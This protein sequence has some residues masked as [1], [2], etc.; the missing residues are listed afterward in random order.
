MQQTTANQPVISR[1]HAAGLLYTEYTEAS[2][3]ERPA[4]RQWL[5]DAEFTSSLQDKMGW[6]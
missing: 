6:I 2:Q 3:A 5:M 1:N 4:S